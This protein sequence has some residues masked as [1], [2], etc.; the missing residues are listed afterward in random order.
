[1]SATAG[2]S[3]NYDYN[4]RKWLDSLVLRS[5]LV[6]VFKEVIR[7]DSTRSDDLVFGLG[8]GCRGVLDLLVEP[9]DAA[10]P[11]RLVSEFRWNGREP[12]EWTTTLPDG[13]VMV[14]IIRPEP[15]IVV[16]G[17]G[18][19]VA[20]VPPSRR[21]VAGARRLRAGSAGAAIAPRPPRCPSPRGR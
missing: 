8:L 20:P 4:R 19:D 5:G 17:G 13:E 18:P 15:A 16:F 12:V 7:Y 21:P 14:E 6:D 2:R 11:P 10:H 9:F 3:V 1:M